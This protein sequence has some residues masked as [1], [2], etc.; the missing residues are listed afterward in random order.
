LNYGHIILLI[1]KYKAIPLIGALVLPLIFKTV[2]IDNVISTFTGTYLFGGL[3]VILNDFSI[4]AAFITIFYLSCSKNICEILSYLLKLLSFLLFIIYLIDIAIIYQFNTHLTLTDIKKYSGYVSTYLQQIYGYSLTIIIM[5]VIVTSLFYL[6]RMTRKIKCD[7]KFKYLPFISMLTIICILLTNNNYVHSWAYQNVISYNLNI[8]AETKNYSKSF[9]QSLKPSVDNYRC[10]NKAI[11]SPNI[12]LLMVESL[13]SYQ[14]K[15]FSGIQNWTPNIDRIA[16]ENRAYT[17]FYANGFTTEDGEVS[18]LTGKPPVPKPAISSNNG[19]TSF[20]GFFSLKDALPFKL[21]NKGYTTEF[22]TTADLSFSNTGAWANS[23]G[24]N[25]TEGSEYNGYDNWTRSY[26][27]AAPDEALY[28]RILQRIQ[29]NIDKRYFIFA[30]TVSTHHPF[31]DP[32]TGKK[33]EEAV[34][35]YSDQQIGKF[36]NTLKDNNFFEQ[37]MLIIVGDHHT[38]VPLMRSETTRFG[39]LRAA[40]RVPL[41][42]SYKNKKLLNTHMH[43]QLDIYNSLQQLPEQ[44]RCGTDWIGDIFLGA[45]LTPKYVIHRRGDNRNI[46]SVFN[47]SNDYSVY[48]SGD[49]SY[50]KNEKGSVDSKTAQYIL[51]R[52]NSLRIGND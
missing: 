49:D 23:I 52:I 11:K 20:S 13:S 41:I 39:D 46:V 44:Q 4:Y 29:I 6:V 9:I 51:N 3:Q 40:S 43:Q 38:M 47:Q 31:I 7:I 37:G 2:Y 22:L 45:E 33:S 17:N 25:Y 42:V 50:V 5:L 8:Y 34:F 12:I 10:V 36:Y 14:S 19:G 15:F 21:R 26:F 30:K 28:Q 32:T 27:N 16:Q 48:L 18:L 1:K 24:F 35:R